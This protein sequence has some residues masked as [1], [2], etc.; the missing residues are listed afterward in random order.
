MSSG[1]GGFFMT[2]CTSTINLGGASKEL[3]AGYSDDF[4]KNTYLSADPLQ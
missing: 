2:W 1:E 3:H 4:T